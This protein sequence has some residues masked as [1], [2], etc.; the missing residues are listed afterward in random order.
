M[1]LLGI[2]GSLRRGSLTR[3]LLLAASAS[4]D[5]LTI[6]EGLAGLPVFNEDLEENAPATVRRMREAIAAADGLLVVTPEY[7]GSI[8]GGLKNALDW[9]S[10]PRTSAALAG[11][12]VAMVA[13]SPGPGGGRSALSDLARVLERAGARVVGEGL[14]VPT[15]HRRLP[16]TPPGSPVREDLE[17]VVG[18]LLAA[19]Q[20]PALLPG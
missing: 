11:K 9:A 14:A 20:G 6:W 7:N 2:C 13:A 5:E 12:P 16:S 8:P 17:V 4:R 18:D 1:R 15:A 3:Q 10:R 19:I